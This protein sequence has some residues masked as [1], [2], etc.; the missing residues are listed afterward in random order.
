MSDETKT[1]KT[2]G[3]LKPVIFLIIFM[4]FFYLLASQMGVGNMLNTMMNTAY[5]LLMETCFY[6]MAVAVLAG[7]IAA[8][9]SEFGV[10]DLVNK[11]LSPLMK[12][13][14]DLPGAAT[15][16]LSVRQSRHHLFGQE[17]QIPKVF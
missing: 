12:P 13:L 14:Y 17:P 15:H 5:S 6:I 7:A 10:V 9:L 1:I 2:N 11:L 8:L 3:V 4:A 16:D